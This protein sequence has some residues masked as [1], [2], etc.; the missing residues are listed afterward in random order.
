MW[1]ALLWRLHRQ[2]KNAPRGG[3][4]PD[5]F[6]SSQ[7]S[8]DPLLIPPIPAGNRCVC[9]IPHMDGLEYSS[10]RVPLSFTLTDTRDS[11]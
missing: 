9:S 10:D 2:S 11:W 6:T 1:D 7:R 4:G 8:I 3:C 5:Y